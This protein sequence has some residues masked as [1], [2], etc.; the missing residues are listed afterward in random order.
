MS[1]R[2][3][4]TLPGRG[5]SYTRFLFDARP[6]GRRYIILQDFIDWLMRRDSE[7]G[8]PSADSLNPLDEAAEAIGGGAQQ[9]SEEQA[10]QEAPI[11]I[12]LLPNPKVGRGQGSGANVD[13]TLEALAQSRSAQSVS[14]N[15]RSQGALERKR[16]STQGVRKRKGG[17]RAN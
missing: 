4:V 5:S 15:W 11:T 12:N 16:V 10:L 17:A 9:R 7:E 1:S 13:S 3:C 14:P 8:G 2:S 6:L